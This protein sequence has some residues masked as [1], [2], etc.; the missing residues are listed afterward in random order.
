MELG[1]FGVSTSQS[2]KTAKHKG[3]KVE[4]TESIASVGVQIIPGL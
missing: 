2:A 3:Q 1:I 4:H